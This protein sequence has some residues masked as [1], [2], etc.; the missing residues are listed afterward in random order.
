[1]SWH[2]GTDLHSCAQ[3]VE[4]GDPERFAAAMAAPVEARAVLMPLYAFNVEVARAPWVTQEPMIARMRLQWWL[5][6]LDEIEAGGF[7]RRHEVVTP[8]AQGLAGVDLSGLRAAVDAR[9][10]DL[11]RAPFADEAALMAY[12]DAT[13]GELALAGVAA[14]GVGP[15]HRGAVLAHARAAA[16]ARYLQAVPE[17]EARGKLPLPDGR[18]EALAALAQARLAELRGQPGL[19]G[20]RRQ[21]GVAGAALREFAQARSLLEIVARD[22]AAVAEG[23][24][25]LSEFQRRWRLL[26]S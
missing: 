6:A 19:R 15:Q 13:A 4:K 3:I 5:D 8:L 17:L 18:P 16:L 9:E 7:V 20:L 24:V 12:L 2:P 21:L 23:R 14:L 11:E 22:P 1:M 26:T 25:T 10:M